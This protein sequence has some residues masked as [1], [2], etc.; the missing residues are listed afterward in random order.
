MPA[1]LVPATLRNVDG[2]TASESYVHPRTG[3]SCI[4]ADHAELYFRFASTSLYFVF[5]LLPVHF[6][7]F[8]L[9]FDH[10]VSFRRIAGAGGGGGEGDSCILK[11]GGVRLTLPAYHTLVGLIVGLIFLGF[12]SFRSLLV[13]ASILAL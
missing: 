9:G 1:S 4:I 11:L 13:A 6:V 8:H 10:S 3:V 7:S 12:R 5:V 2:P